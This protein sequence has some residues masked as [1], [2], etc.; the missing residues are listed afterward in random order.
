MFN[1]KTYE[2][3]KELNIFEYSYKNNFKFFCE[4]DLFL[5]DPLLEKQKQ[6]ITL[7]KEKITDIIN[8]MNLSE[9][10]KERMINKKERYI[11]VL[12]GYQYLYSLLLYDNFNSK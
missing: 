4:K 2:I 9:R 7:N 11:L 10:M 1:Y 8:N 6:Y 12:Y 3:L 5:N